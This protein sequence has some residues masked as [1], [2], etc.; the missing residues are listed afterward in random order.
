MVFGAI[1]GD[2]IG[3]LYEINPVKTKDFEWLNPYSRFTDDTVLTVAVASALL[4]NREYGKA[5]KT[6]ARRYPFA[7]Y[8]DR[9]D[10][11]AQ[12][13][14]YAPYNSCGN[15]SAMRVSGVGYAFD[16]LE[17]VV[18]EARET[19]RVTHNHPEGIK[20]AQAVAACI[21][22]ARTGVEKAAIKQVIATC[23]QYDLD[24][25]LD[26][27]RP[28]YFFDVTCQGSVPQSIVAFLESD[29]FESA[30]RNAISL[31]GDSD[32]MA[33]IAGSIA[34]AYYRHIPSEIIEFVR[35]KLPA[36]LLE[37]VDAFNERF[38]VKY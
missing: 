11:W 21:F 8:G 17:D 27:I 22:L 29:N 6:F 5:L 33:C 36:E 14:S 18:F 35:R 10:H 26:E 15:G 24:Q 19:A 9:F 25:K 13:D 2:M 20:G 3:S 34:Q 32:T 31:G 37:V 12:D 1:C 23:F 7:G 4:G 16:S 38:E 30:I 28:A